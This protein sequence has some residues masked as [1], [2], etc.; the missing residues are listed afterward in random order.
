MI[1]PGTRVLMLLHRHPGSPVAF[2]T[3]RA[4]GRNPCGDLVYEI[5]TANGRIFALA[6][7]VHEV[8]AGVEPA[9]ICNKGGWA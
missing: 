7:H 9:Q 3:A 1:A 2:G 8:P 6:D 4:S 5:K